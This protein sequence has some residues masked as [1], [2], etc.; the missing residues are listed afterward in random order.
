MRAHLVLLEHLV[1]HQRLH[2]VNL[3]CIGL[4]AQSDLE[5]EQTQG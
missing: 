3:A 4:L 1:L 5:G 2:R